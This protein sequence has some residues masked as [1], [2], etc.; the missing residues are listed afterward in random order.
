MC[1]WLRWSWTAVICIHA[2]IPSKTIFVT[3]S[4]LRGYGAITA[5]DW[6]SVSINMKWIGSCLCNWYFTFRTGWGQDH[7]FTPDYHF[8]YP[9]AFRDS[10]VIL[11][12]VKIIE[13]YLYVI[14]IY[15]PASF[16]EIASCYPPGSWA[17]EKVHVCFGQPPSL[18]IHIILVDGCV[19]GK[20]PDLGNVS[21]RIGLN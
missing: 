18:E 11:Q 21:K 17:C 10:V 5:I 2:L 4:Y 16:F 12:Y 3:A 8:F 14:S 15:T 20:R 1:C 13:C 7:M 9:D 6:S 19:F